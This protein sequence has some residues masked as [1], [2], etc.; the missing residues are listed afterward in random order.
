[1]SDPPA[2]GPSRP[3]DAAGLGPGAID[4]YG[5][6]AAL[7][8]DVEPTF[9]HAE[10][11]ELAVLERNGLV[12][13]SAAGVEVVA[14]FGQL[15]DAVREQASRLESLRST[16][17]ALERLWLSRPSRA[18][19]IELVHG[20]ASAQAFRRMLAEPGT[21]RAMHRRSSA[22]VTVADGTFDLLARGVSIQVVYD[23]TLL[24]Q[25]AALVAARKCMAAGEEAR[26]LPEVP[27]SIVLTD[28]M[29]SIALP[30]EA[31]PPDRLLVHSPPVLGVLATLFESFWDK[32]IPFGG[33]TDEGADDE[34]SRAIVALLASGLTDA[35]IGRELNI[36]E[37]TVQRRIVHLQG[38]LG[39]RTRFQ[40]GVQAARQGWLS[41]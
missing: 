13:R 16:A 11:P 31:D 36:S 22:T 28:Q 33:E 9:E 5:V 8:A 20:A 34:D 32:A 19:L 21:V 3:E 7:G 35:S 37:R 41:D 15:D 23:A 26:V 4:L 29:A 6:L 24:T 18:G 38:R 12:R 14:P 2:P 39:A 27:M 1:M 30:G 10:S 17:D 25:P 40:L